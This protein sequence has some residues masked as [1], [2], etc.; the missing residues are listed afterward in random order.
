MGNKSIQKKQYI[1]KTAAKVFAQMGFKKVTMKDIVEACQISRGGLYLYFADT[2]EIFEAVLA[3]N[4]QTGLQVL[5]NA[6]DDE[7]PEK[8]LLSYLDT[9]KKE[10]I[11][12][13]DNL[14][15]ATFEYLF[16]MKAEKKENP[17]KKAYQEEIKALEELISSGVKKKGMLCDN[18]VVAAKNI[19]ITLE[20]IKV[21][22]QTYGLSAKAADQAVE[23]ILGSVGL[24]TR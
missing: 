2:R 13:K 19:M 14:E 10:L 16:E 24:V 11:K 20:G 7:E 12:K 3:M 5:K 15:V 17:L 22:A 6:S 1:V 21:T 9:K 4:E 23:S 18:P 8:I